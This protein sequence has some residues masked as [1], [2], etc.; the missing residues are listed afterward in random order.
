[1]FMLP[2][3]T[4]AIKK[5]LKKKLEGK[6]AE[7]VKYINNYIDIPKMT[8]AQEKVLFDQIYNAFQ[9]VIEEKLLD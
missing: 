9:G 8:E 2:W 3:V 5:I 6:Q 4:K 1:M 7:V